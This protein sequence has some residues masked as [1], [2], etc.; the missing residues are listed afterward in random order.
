MQSIHAIMQGH[1]NHETYPIPDITGQA[2]IDF[3]QDIKTGPTELQKEVMKRAT[4]KFAKTKKQK[5]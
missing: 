5:Q 4:A 3:E 1:H 2:A